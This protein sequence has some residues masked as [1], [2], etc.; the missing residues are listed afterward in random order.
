MVVRTWRPPRDLGEEILKTQ[1]G[2]GKGRE[3]GRQK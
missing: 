3:G 2:R 1:R